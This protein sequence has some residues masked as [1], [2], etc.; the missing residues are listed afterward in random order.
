VGVGSIGEGGRV[1]GEKKKKEMGLYLTSLLPCTNE[2]K[3]A[4]RIW[5]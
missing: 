5:R 3:M 4:V 2:P 1:E